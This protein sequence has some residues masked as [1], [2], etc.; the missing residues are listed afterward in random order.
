MYLF[1]LTLFA[2]RRSI[3]RE[4]SEFKATMINMINIALNTETMSKTL[5]VKT[6]SEKK[7]KKPFYEFLEDAVVAEKTRKSILNSIF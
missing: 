3:H 2:K 5:K 4:S 6:I 1:A 7:K